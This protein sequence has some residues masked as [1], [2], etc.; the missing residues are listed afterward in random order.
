M[1]ISGFQFIDCGFQSGLKFC[2]AE[3]ALYLKDCDPV[4]SIG[5][6]TP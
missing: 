6:D 3:V 5:Q 4:L 2:K 1:Y